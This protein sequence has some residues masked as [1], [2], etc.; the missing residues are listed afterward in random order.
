MEDITT[1]TS[2]ADPL[3]ISIIITC[4]RGRDLRFPGAPVRVL[5]R[6]HLQVL[7]LG[8]RR[9]T[10]WP[11]WEVWV[12]ERPERLFLRDFS[13]RTTRPVTVQW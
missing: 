11:K 4:F 8:T 9:S 3:C 5:L 7:E 10:T 1:G 13:Q 6:L 12:D 2:P